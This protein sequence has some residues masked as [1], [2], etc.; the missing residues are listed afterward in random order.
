MHSQIYLSS[1]QCSCGQSNGERIVGGQQVHPPYKYPWL[2]GLT[3]YPFRMYH[4][5][6]TILTTEIVLTA[7]HCLYDPSSGRV[8]SLNKLK[9]KVADHDQFSHVDDIK[10]V[11]RLLDVKE[12]IP[13]EYFIMYRNYHDIGL[14]RLATTLDLKSYPQVRAVC[15]PSNSALTYEGAVGVAYGWGVKKENSNQP[16]DVPHEVELYILGPTCKNTKFGDVT[17]TSN[18]LCAGVDE[19]GKDTC[20]GD[21]GGPI[22]VEVNYRHVI[23]GITSFGNGCGKIEFPGVYTR[24][25]AY[26]P[27]IHSKVRGTCTNT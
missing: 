1:G 24:I 10:G 26:L 4:C 3:S 9:V 17:L 18:M 2:V 19:G 7:G 12:I 15:L 14:V 22:T 11:T 27:W 23:V 13:H 5:G 8:Y 16:A 20:L 21:S 6:G 25:T